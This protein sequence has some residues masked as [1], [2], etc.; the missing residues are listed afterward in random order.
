[1]FNFVKKL[2][3]A[4]QFKME[5]GE[6]EMLGQRMLIIP[7]YTFAYMIKNSTDPIESG[8]NMYHACKHV[9]MDDVGFTYEISEKFGIKG[10]DLIKWMADIATMA[11]FGIIKIVNIDEEKKTALVHIE[12]SP[13]TEFIGQSKYP[14]DH[15]IRGY[16]AG[17]AEVVFNGLGKKSGEWKK[18][19]Y[20]ET[21]CRS[22]S[23]NICEFVLVKRD[24]LKKSND[25]K[26]KNLYK[27]QVGGW[28]S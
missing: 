8:K 18:Y 28:K 16:M 24:E 27:A 20:I 15:A 6:I 13:I 11:G 21:K 9:N 19:D 25:K 26:M 5:K 12:D 10:V 4:R 2:M 7:S 22:L 14:V 1:M 23:D 3:F 17:A